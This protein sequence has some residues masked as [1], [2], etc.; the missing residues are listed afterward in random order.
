M[1]GRRALVR[2]LARLLRPAALEAEPGA[3]RAIAGAASAR[4]ADAAA[5]GAAADGAAAAAAA[6]APGAADARPLVRR[7][8][9]PFPISARLAEVWDRVEGVEEEELIR[10]HRA[11]AAKLRGAAGAAGEAGAPPR[12]PGRPPAE[13][14][15]A[16]PRGPPTAA[17]YRLAA[18]AAEALVAASAAL[19]GGPPPGVADADL[20][21]LRGLAAALRTDP[22]L[23]GEPPAGAG[24]AGSDAAA[25]AASAARSGA[26]APAARLAAALASPPVVNAAPPGRLPWEVLAVDEGRGIVHWGTDLTDG[27]APDPWRAAL[28]TDD[29]KAL[30]ARWSAEAPDGRGAPEALAA[31]FGVRVQRVLAAVELK[32]REAAAEAEVE[33]ATAAAARRAEKLAASAARRAAHLAAAAGG[34]GGE[35]AEAG[36]EASAEPAAEP[37]D[38]SAAAAAAPAA[39]PPPGAAAQAAEL[40][41]LAAWLERAGHGADAATGPGEAHRVTLPSFPSYAPVEGNVDAERVL[42]RLAAALG[43]ASIDDVGEEDVTPA[44][45]RAALGIESAEEIGAALAAAEEAGAVAEFSAALARNARVAGG[46][47]AARA[48]ARAARRRPKGGRDLVVTPVGGGGGE[49]E[50]YAVRPDGSRRPLAEA[51]AEGAARRTPR[52]RRRLL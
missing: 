39:P 6:A 44:R 35:G 11:R 40:A 47:G 38:A 9:L 2:G 43:R 41:E 37:A 13:G 52:P 29:A 45:A 4:A 23:A 16:P 7:P 27:A 48:A 14:A 10:R 22:S 3:A 18:E 36:A 49:R 34:E 28:L 31:R 24:G 46:G 33:A 50:A 30:M 8:G 51:E 42:A 25:A 19:P 1:A 15:A 21:L 12:R 17:D 20:A 5:D 26:A 32:R